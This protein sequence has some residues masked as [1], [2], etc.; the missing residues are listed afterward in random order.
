MIL[1]ERFHETMRFNK[2]VSAPKWEFGYWGQTIDNWYGEGLPKHRYP[3]IPTEISTPS[4]SLYVPC[5][6]SIAGDKLPAGIAVLGG[7]LYWP[8]QGFA[9]DHDVKR[10]LNM[11][12][13]QRLI[14]VNL[15]FHPMFETEIIKETDTHLEYVDI[16]GVKRL[17]LKE[18]G[19][20]PSGLEYVITDRKSWDKL[21]DERLNLDDIAGRF[22][23]N[24]DT[25]V[26]EYKLDDCI[27][28]LGGY[29]HGYFGT[30]AQLMGYEHLFFNYFDEP[31]MIHDIQE[32]F[33][34]IWL[35]VYE[36]VLSQ[37]D[38]DLFIIWEDMSAGSGSMVSP[39]VIREFM[40]PYYKRL[41]AF[42]KQHGVS[43][44]FIDTDGDCFDIIPLFI[45]SGITGMYP[46]EVSCGMDLVKIRKTYPE[47]Q[48]MGGIPKSEILHGKQRIDEILEPV[49]EVLKTGGYIPY[50]DHLIPPEVP[51]EQFSYYRTKLNDMID[52]R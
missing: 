23:S 29:P 52:G 21:K 8:T 19:V 26:E 37:V 11:D 35:T 44:I 51:W 41:T 49:G 14:D 6:N 32:T 20:I 36:E 7:G 25:C 33:T 16:D 9:L 3:E 12:E 24:W 46:I 10:A 45:E 4:S 18:T 42:L 2:K 34:R 47:L 5:W 30:L 28:T 1:K 17:F 31:A 43:T 48:L 15:L 27:V 50:G 13:G 38:V 22:P 40:V 39:A